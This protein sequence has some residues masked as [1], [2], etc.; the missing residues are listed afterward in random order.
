M[1]IKIIEN[2]NI[3]ILLKII[4]IIISL[5]IIGIMI[6]DWIINWIV[7]KEIKLPSITL[8]GFTLLSLNFLNSKIRS[9]YH[10]GDIIEKIYLKSDDENKEKLYNYALEI[11]ET[12]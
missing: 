4:N 2:H 9:L 11:K 7:T 6:Y 1:K 8:Y 12:R 10:K 5:A 3:I